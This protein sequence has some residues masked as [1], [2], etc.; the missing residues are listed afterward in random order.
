[1]S[2]AEWGSELEARWAH[3]WR[4]EEVA[5]RLVGVEAPWYVAAG[6]ALEL[7]VGEPWRAHADLEIG[8]PANGFGEV[9]ARFPGV[10]L[11]VPVEGRVWFDVAPEVLAVTHQT[12]LRD[13][14]T[15]GYL[16]DVF[17]EPSEGDLWICRRDEGIRLPYGE[18]VERTAEGVPYLAP[19]LVLL[20]KAGEVRPKDQE[21]FELVLPLLGSRRLSRLR[22]WLRRGH[23]GHPWL[24]A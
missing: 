20:F 24:A 23:H 1:M 22:A 12:W 14:A 18:V 19:E 11:D 9:L 5:A 6:W 17:R 2:S 3:A 10:V 7:F 8:V 21:D 13:P 4:P 16:C 15:D